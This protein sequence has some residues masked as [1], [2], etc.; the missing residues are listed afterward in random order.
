MRSYN[1]FRLEQQPLETRVHVSQAVKLKKHI[2]LIETLLQIFLSGSV[3]LRYI[4]GKS[5]NPSWGVIMY[6]FI[7][8]SMSS[9][10]VAY[11]TTIVLA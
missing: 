1:H 5:D 6:I 7:Y 8:H 10:V 9:C 4:L 3:I 2:S 11:L